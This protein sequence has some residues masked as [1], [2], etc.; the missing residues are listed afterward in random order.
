LSKLRVAILISS[1]ES[2]QY[3]QPVRVRRHRSHELAKYLAADTQRQSK[4]RR[5][6]S[7]REIQAS[8]MSAE[9]VAKAFVQHYYTTFDTNRPGL[10]SLY[11]RLAIGCLSTALRWW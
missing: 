4:R 6:G 1:N 9:D 3:F 10:A 2:D 7:K 11:V 8:I 5:E